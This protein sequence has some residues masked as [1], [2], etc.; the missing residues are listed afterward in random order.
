VPRDEF[1]CG[2]VRDDGDVTAAQLV[3]PA[4]RLLSG[5]AACMAARCCICMAWR[6]APPY[7]S[8]VMLA[9]RVWAYASVG[10]ELVVRGGDLSCEVET[11]HGGTSSGELVGDAANWPKTGRLDCVGLDQG[12]FSSLS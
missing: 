11:C 8:V 2:R 5:Q 3:R 9:P 4:L 7:A 6:F 12:L 1:A 10:N